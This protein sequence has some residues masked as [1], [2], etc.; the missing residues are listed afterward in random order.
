MLIKLLIF[1]GLAFICVPLRSQVRSDSMQTAWE[2]ILHKNGQDPKEVPDSLLEYLKIDL[3]KFSEITIVDVNPFLGDAVIG[4]HPIIE[5]IHRM[6]PQARITYISPSAR[7]LVPR[8]W[9]NPIV[10]NW[11]DVY[12]AIRSPLPLGQSASFNEVVL[13]HI[14][15]GVPKNSFVFF[16]A[17]TNRHGFGRAFEKIKDQMPSGMEAFA[18]GSGFQKRI[19]RALLGKNAQGL[20]TDVDGFS[21]NAVHVHPGQTREVNFDLDLRYEG[22]A[23]PV[24]GESLRNTTNVY[25]NKLLRRLVVFG[26]RIHE[27]SDGMSD[28]YYDPSRNTRMNEYMI[29]V[30]G[31]DSIDPV[32][33][34]LNTVAS[35]KIEDS[36]SSYLERLDFIVKS[37]RS[38]DPNASILVTAPEAH[39]GPDLRAAVETYISDS[40][41]VLGGRVKFM[42]EDPKLWQNILKRARFVISQ[43]SGFLHIANALLPREK[44]MMLATLSVGYFPDHWKRSEQP[45]IIFYKGSDIKPTQFDQLKKWIE[46]Q[47]NVQPS[48]KNRLRCILSAV[49]ELL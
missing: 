31:S 17:A 16:E 5:G 19:I 18:K 44:V 33:I 34:N 1:V 8:T 38:I 41:G 48:P 10:F 15:K 12:G 7:V 26:D 11:D 35:F 3:N 46:Q 27:N 43:D 24:F 9:L 28:L 6:H 47:L 29:K 39:Y 20:I 40:Q 49:R 25:E 23:S 14:M 2:D 4:S 32:L 13:D 21:I 30:F 22:K 36:K 45:A 37:I 42:P